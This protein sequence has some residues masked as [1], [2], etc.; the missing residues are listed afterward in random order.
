MHQ[1]LGRQHDHL[2]NGHEKGQ[3]Q[4][5]ESCTSV[6]A[7]V[8]S[9]LLMGRREVVCNIWRHAPECWWVRLLIINGQK[10]GFATSRVIHLSVGG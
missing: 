3:L 8:T 5:L 7:D 9:P 1:S 10:K 6:W 2:A 4:H